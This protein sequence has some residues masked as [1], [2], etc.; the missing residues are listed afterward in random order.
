MRFKFYNKTADKITNSGV[1]SKSYRDPLSKLFLSGKKVEKIYNKH[2]IKYKKSATC[3]I[4]CSFYGSKLKK[5]EFYLSALK[6]LF[7]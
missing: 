5:P 2:L 3:R 6:I 4:E 7:N 1:S